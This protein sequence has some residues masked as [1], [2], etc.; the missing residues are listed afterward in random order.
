MIEFKPCK[1]LYHDFQPFEIHNMV[2]EFVI[3][4][5]PGDIDKVG[6]YDQTVQNINKAMLDPTNT[7]QFWL[8][9]ASTKCLG[10]MLTNITTDVDNSKCFYMYLG[11]AKPEIRNTPLVKHCINVLR[12]EAK[13]QNCKYVIYPTSHS[14]QV[15][16]RFLGRTTTK[17]C[18]LL[19][20]KL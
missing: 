3:D 18:T 7:H 14:P 11:Y 2:M 5:N 6:Y 4:S 10:F 9:Q 1:S 17:Y 19:K 16:D 13:K 8:L 12:E 15:F 20:E